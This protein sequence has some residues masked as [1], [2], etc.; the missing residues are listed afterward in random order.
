VLEDV[1][2]I[3]AGGRA[4]L[5]VCLICLFCVGCSTAAAL[6]GGSFAGPFMVLLDGFL[7]GAG[8]WLLE[9]FSVLV[10]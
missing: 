2:L 5:D 8:G 3:D 7:V 6:R 1:S 4:Y 10:W 9:L